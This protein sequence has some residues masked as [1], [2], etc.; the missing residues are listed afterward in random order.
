MSDRLVIRLGVAGC[1]VLPSPVAAIT[2][3]MTTTVAAALLPVLT[4]GAILRKRGWRR[5][6]QLE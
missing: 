5:P 1:L 2:H 4:G 6:D 3:D